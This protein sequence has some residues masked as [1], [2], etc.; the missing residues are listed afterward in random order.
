MS[1]KAVYWVK[2]SPEEQECE[3][4]KGDTHGV[5]LLDGKN[6]QIGYIPYDQ[7]NHVVPA[8]DHQ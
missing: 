3:G 8:D 5:H 1:L 7:L 2:D 6:S 4:V